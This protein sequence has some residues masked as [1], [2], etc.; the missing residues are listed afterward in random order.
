[1][2]PDKQLRH[3]VTFFLLAK[4]MCAASCQQTFKNLNQCKYEK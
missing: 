4:K 3:Q 1:M 2:A